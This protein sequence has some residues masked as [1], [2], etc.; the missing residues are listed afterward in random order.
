V[1]I[2]SLL[3]ILIAVAIGAVWFFGGSTPEPAAPAKSSSIDAWLAPQDWQKRRDAPV[4]T[5]GLEG[6][7]DDMHVFAPAVVRE[8]GLYRLWYPGSRGTVAGR[9]FRIGLAT[10]SDGVRFK[11]A[12]KTPVYSFGGAVSIVTPTVLRNT[13]GTPIREDGKLR[14]WFTSVD[15]SDG[16]HSLHDSLSSD[17]VAWSAP[18]DSLLDNVYAPTVIK[19][20]SIYRMWYTDVGVP[21]WTIRHASSP[22]GKTWN[23]TPKPV[24]EVEQNW[25]HRRL[26]YPTVV[27]HDGLYLLWYASYWIEAPDADK[28]GIGFAVSEDGIHWRKNPNNPV[29]RPDSDLLWEAYYNSSQ[30]VMRLPDGMWRIWYGSRKEPPFI[31]KYFAIAS[32]TWTGPKGN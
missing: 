31:N 20:G 24:L 3:K 28:T 18:S 13:D 16:I 19:D 12:A 14:M 4:I 6:A 7:F 29:L 30:S 27:K 11:K 1:R 15:F 5:L 2:T 21:S 22:D 17:G 32:A 23:V 9:V 10:S 8:K 25:E 26:F